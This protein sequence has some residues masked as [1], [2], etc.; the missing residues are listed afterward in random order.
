[1]ITKHAIRRYQER[2]RHCSVS[3][4]KEQIEAIYVMGRLTSTLPAGDRFFALG[5]V[6]IVVDPRN[7]CMTVYTIGDGKAKDVGSGPA[8]QPQKRRRN[9]RSL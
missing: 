3:V 7:R 9:G 6:R 5:C 4:A 2:V 8:C 1:M